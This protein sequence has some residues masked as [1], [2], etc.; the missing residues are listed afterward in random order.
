MLQ[1]A[2]TDTTLFPTGQQALVKG[3]SYS[4]LKLAEPLRSPLG[5]GTTLTLTTKGTILSQAPGGETQVVTTSGSN[6]A[7]S[8]TV[9]VNSFTA[10]FNFPTDTAILGD[11]SYACPGFA[12]G[13]APG[14]GSLAALN[15]SVSPSY[16]PAS[17]TQSAGSADLNR[18]FL[19]YLLSN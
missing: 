6:P 18:V 14:Y 12:G 11:G 4:S 17:V 1:L 10:K 3:S 19:D 7:G 16:V 13:K 8:S 5:A 9:T 2:V 15:T